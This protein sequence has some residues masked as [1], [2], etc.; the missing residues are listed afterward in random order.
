[1]YGSRPARVLTAEEREHARILNVR[2]NEL[3]DEAQLL[4]G[5]VVFERDAVLVALFHDLITALGDEM[6][7]LRLEELT[8]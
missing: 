4:R 6:A 7:L 2:L 1:V 5:L 8:A 3:R